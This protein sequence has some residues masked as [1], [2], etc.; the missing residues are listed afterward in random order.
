MES[1]RWSRRRVVV[2]G[3]GV[4]VC[5]LTLAACM[6]GTTGGGP[7]RGAVLF[8]ERVDEALA[9]ETVSP[10]AKEFLA[11]LRPRGEMTYEDYRRGLTLR[12]DCLRDLGIEIRFYE[13][14][15]EGVPDVFS[16]VRAVPGSGVDPEMVPEISWPCEEST[17]LPIALTYLEQQSSVE[18]RAEYFDRFRGPLIDCLAELGF[19]VPG[20][21]AFD[22][23]MGEIEI[24]LDQ[25]RTDCR[26]ETGYYP[27]Q[28]VPEE[29]WLDW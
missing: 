17:Y 6:G 27:D 10:V 20:D 7:E 11:E 8:E 9:S 3:A 26:L 24:A 4:V 23:V 12:Q 14:T 16:A 22:E 25:T 1:R 28:T 2:A 29:D 21:A 19:D 18:L 15:N 13:T 5:C